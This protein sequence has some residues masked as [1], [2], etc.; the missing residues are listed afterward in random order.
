MSPQ[1]ESLNTIKILK[2]TEMRTGTTRA[3][4]TDVDAGVSKANDGRIELSCSKAAY[5]I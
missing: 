2:G 3:Y 1:L 4:S 5:L